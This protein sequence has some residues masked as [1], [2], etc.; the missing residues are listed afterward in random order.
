MK[1]YSKGTVEVVDAGLNLLVMDGDWQYRRVEV[2]ISLRTSHSSP[3]IV[4][5]EVSGSNPDPCTDSRAPPP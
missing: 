4:T 3:Q 1:D 2:D 5:V